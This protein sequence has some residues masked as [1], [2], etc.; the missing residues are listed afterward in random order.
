[1]TWLERLLISVNPTLLVSGTPW[2]RLWR[3]KEREDF[4]RVARAFFLLAFAGYLGHYHFFDVPMGLEPRERWFYF[5]YGMATI[6]ALC[7][8]FYFSPLVRRTS[9]KL[10]LVLATLVFCTFQGQVRAWYPEANYLYCFAFSFIGAIIVRTSIPLSIIYIAACSALQT[11]F[12]ISAGDSIP[13]I[14]SATAVT[15]LFAGI[16]RSNH[17]A[18]IRY[19]LA[20]QE[21]IATQKKIIELNIEFADRMRAFV[22]KVIYGRLE[23]EMNDSQ[24]SAL[25]AIDNVLTPRKVT[26]ACLFSDIRG[27]TQASRD[28][29]TYVDKGVWPNVKACTEAVELNQGIP[30]KV[31]DLIFSYFDDENLRV[32]LIRCLRAGMQVARLNIDMNETR[33]EIAID[34]YILISVGDAI[35]GNLGG[36]DSSIEITALGSPVNF[37]SRLD[38]V[39]KTEYLQSRISPSD[40]IICERSK[41]LLDEMGLD[42]EFLEISLDQDGLSIRDFPSVQKIYTLRPTERNYEVVD[43]SYDYVQK[44]L[45]RDAADEASRI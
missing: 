13:L 23:S 44:K 30:R 34:R 22:P 43:G 24:I 17:I 37:L 26:V 14:V 16:V 5:R 42:L 11:P 39:T 8:A 20:N 1:M 10:P 15:C 29:D 4:V 41:S 36:F 28:I 9:Y 35:V 40:I 19:F 7:L 25:Q 31:G 6:C 33:N 3:E 27:F 2:E 32:N 38:E 45:K 12:L 21:N 18:E